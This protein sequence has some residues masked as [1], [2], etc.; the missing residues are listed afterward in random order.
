MKTGIERR[1]GDY[2]LIEEGF[3]ESALGEHVLL[4]RK[5]LL[6]KMP[7]SPSMP[8]WETVQEKIAMLGNLS[9][10]HLARL[11]DVL[12]EEDVCYF[13]YDGLPA[14]FVSLDCFVREYKADEEQIRKIAYQIAEALDALHHQHLL[15]LAVRASNV[16]VDTTQKEPFAILV[17]AG[18]SALIPP[19]DLLQKLL[20]GCLANDHPLFWES[21]HALSPEQKE[22]KVSR[23]SDAY[24]LGVMLY[25]L[26]V[27]KYPQGRFSLPSEELMLVYAWDDL[28]ARLLACAPDKRPRDLALELLNIG[29]GDSALRPKRERGELCRPQLDMDPASVFHIDSA[30]VRYQPQLQE[31]KSVQPL[32]TKMVI[33]SSGSFHRGSVQGGR[34][35]IPRHRVELKAYALDEHPVTNEQFVRFLEIMGGEKDGNNHDMIRLKESRIKKHAGQFIVEAGYSKHPVVGVSWYGAIAYAKWLG[36]RLPT[37]AEWE[38]AAC[39]GLAGPLY[40]TGEEISKHEANFF[41]SDTTP[42]ASYAPNGYGLYDMAGNVYEWCLDWYDYHAYEISAQEPHNPQ[43]PQQGVYRVLRGGG[44]KSLKEDMRCSY[45]HRNNPGTM[46]ATYGFRCAADVDLS[47][48]KES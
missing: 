8:S 41:S 16:F 42:V 15:H 17:D 1:I 46:N 28:L 48:C 47:H 24:A 34:D 2:T 36:K 10:P 39:G 13:V 4:K 6:K 26:L 20:Q 11:Q 14:H 40:P 30:I 7:L 29:G 33:I 21:F 35:E 44:W 9:H 43:G 3:G 5:V 38:I 45:R 22:G 32:D 31:E 19:Q 25:K 37:E 27:G 18:L 23:E 12:M